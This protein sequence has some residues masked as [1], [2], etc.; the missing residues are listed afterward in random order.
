[1]AEQ[2]SIEEKFK[3]VANHLLKS[4]SSMISDA[5]DAKLTKIVSNQVDTMIDLLNKQPADT[6]IEGFLAKNKLWDLKALKNKDMD[7]LLEKVPLMF[8][9]IPLI[10]TEILIEPIKIYQNQPKVSKKAPVI[11]KQEIDIVWDDITKLVKASCIYNSEHGH[12]YVLTV[13]N[14]EW[15]IAGPSKKK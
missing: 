1:M 9:G 3:I 6:L 11:S 2:L 4:I 15:N 5:N 7:F 10:D 8:A 13:Y 14:A 12:K